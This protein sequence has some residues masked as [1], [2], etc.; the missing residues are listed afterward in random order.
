M[1]PAKDISL[2]EAFK[3]LEDL[4]ASFESSQT[5]L[6]KSIPKFKRGLELSKQIKTKLSQMENEIEEIK[7]EFKDEDTT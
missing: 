3:E 4:V 1:K 2:S 7:S 6:E 5:D